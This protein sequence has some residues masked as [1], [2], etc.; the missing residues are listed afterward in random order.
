MRDEQIALKEKDCYSTAK[1]TR[2]QNNRLLMTEDSIA[3]EVPV[4][5]IFNGISHVVMMASP[6]DLDDFALGFSLSEGIVRHVR[7]IYEVTIH[8][9]GNDLEAGIEVQLTISNERMAQL[10]LKRRNLAGRTGCGLC[11]AESLQQAILPIN[12][13]PKVAMLKAEPV[14][15]AVTQLSQHQPLQ[16][17]TG[18]FH[19][20]A[21]CDLAG[22]IKIIREDVGRHN[23]LDKLLGALKSSTTDLNQGFVLISSRASYEMVHKVCCCDI[24]TLVAVSAPTKLAIDLAKQAGLN[25]I[26]FARKGSHVVY[27]QAT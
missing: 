12:L 14:Q 21:W 2:W 4:A 20:A 7:E 24:A 22:N 5:M 3:Q 18:A 26:G 9:V 6:A 11:G 27:T 23:A 16:A 19:G 25:L 1:I 8:C 10:K 17:L 15:Q 13:V